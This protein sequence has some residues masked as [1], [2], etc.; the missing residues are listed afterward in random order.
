LLLVLIFLN[1]IIIVRHLRQKGAAASDSE[2]ESLVP[3]RPGDDFYDFACPDIELVDN[4]GKLRTLRELHGV[5]TIIRFTS[6]L[7]SEFKDI[8][9][10]DHIQRCLKDDKVQ[11]IFICPTKRHDSLLLDARSGRLSVP[12]IKAEP[13]FPALFHSG[14]SDTIIIGPDLKIKFRQQNP[15]HRT[16][17]QQAVRLMRPDTL[18]RKSPS[19]SMIMR[20]IKSIRFRDL[21]SGRLEKLYDTINNRIVIMGLFLTACYACPV[22]A[23]IRTVQEALGGEGKE[24]ILALFLFGLGNQIEDVEEVRERYQLFGSNIVTGIIEAVEGPGAGEYCHLFDYLIDPR[25]FVFGNNDIFFLETGENTQK[26]TPEYLFRLIT[27]ISERT[28]NRKPGI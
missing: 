2:P 25:L 24:N 16:I 15:S 26:I 3:D 5:V 1:T 14:S 18:K 8:I 27:E 11:V 10:L 12:I 19:T 6:F 17:Y 13:D 7:R 9:F 28:A 20:T 23:K 4:R 21:D 22:D